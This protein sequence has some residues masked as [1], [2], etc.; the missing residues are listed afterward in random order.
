MGTGISSVV[1]QLTTR[2]LTM[3]KCRAEQT[4]VCRRVL[5][6]FPHR[7][8]VG[9]FIRRLPLAVNREAS[10]SI[11]ERCG[12]ISA[13]ASS[14]AISGAIEEPLELAMS[15]HPR[16]SSPCL[17]PGECA[18]Y[19]VDVAF[20]TRPTALGKTDVAPWGCRRGKSKRTPLK[21]TGI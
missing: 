21:K 20:A 3:H 17:F 16:W 19:R 10:T 8:C 4:Q 5:K 18:I 13:A 15:R 12:R 2:M 6:T 1:V 11:A 9:P 14:Q 7:D